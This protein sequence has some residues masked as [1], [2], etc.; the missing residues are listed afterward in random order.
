M[1][2]HRRIEN[3]LVYT[4]LI[5]FEEEDAYIVKVASSIE[6]FSGLLESEFE[7]V[8]DYEGRKVLRKRK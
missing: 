1:L 4:H 5:D 8:S 3:T 2:G 7:Y 6:E